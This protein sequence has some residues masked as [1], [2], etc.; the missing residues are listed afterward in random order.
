M[1]RPDVQGDDVAAS[2]APDISDV[3]DKTCN[4]DSADLDEAYGCGKAKYMVK[5]RGEDV[6]DVFTLLPKWITRVFQP[7]S[8]RFKEV[9]DK[10]YEHWFRNRPAL[11]VLPLGDSVT[12]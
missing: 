10:I 5:H 6:S 4:P 1:N 9:G 3:D 12:Y 7:K 11:H 8:A 2:K